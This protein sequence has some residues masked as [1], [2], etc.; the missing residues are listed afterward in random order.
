MIEYL[1]TSVGMLTITVL[2]LLVIV[3]AL[4]TAIRQKE[5]IIQHLQEK[6][7]QRQSQSSPS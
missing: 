1:Q 3:V 5:K 6:L 2:A 7:S 4:L